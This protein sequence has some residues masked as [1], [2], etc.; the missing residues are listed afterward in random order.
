MGRKVVCQICKTKG[1]SDIF[2]KVTDDKG[3]N[4]YYCNKEEYDNL[5]LEQKKFKD[6]M[7]Y[8]AEEV[9][10]YEDGQIVPPVI[11]KKVR[12]MN[13]FYDYDV[14]H[15]CFSINKETIQ[16]WI[17]NK[18]FDSEYGMSSYIM[19]IIESSINDV[20]NKWKHRKTVEQRQENDSI[21]LIINE[22]VKQTSNN[23]KNNAILEFL[24]EEDI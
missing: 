4:K 21:N 5:K 2:Y 3:K 23:N 24:D 13:K 8:V 19:K 17:N 11:V 20:Y 1:D 7:V 6:L 12:N 14:I 9:L 10:G 22:E 18:N 16:Y 15:E